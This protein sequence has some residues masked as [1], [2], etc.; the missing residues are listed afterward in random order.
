[1]AGGDHLPHMQ[2]LTSSWHQLS[3]RGVFWPL[4]CKGKL[5]SLGSSGSAAH[6]GLKQLIPDTGGLL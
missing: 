1:M 6:Q 4:K 2:V 3:A 5:L